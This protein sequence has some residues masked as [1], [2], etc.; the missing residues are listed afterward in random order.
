MDDAGNRISLAAQPARR[1]V[2]L[3][4]YITELLFAAG[5]GTALVGASEFSD[6]PGAAR[7]IPRIGGG[8]GLDLEAIIAL[9]PDLVIAWQSG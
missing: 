6:Y 8:N 5:A 7:E 2:S 3:A 1:I 4:P 9:E